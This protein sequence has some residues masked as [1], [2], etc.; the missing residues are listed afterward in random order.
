MHTV[1][2]LLDDVDYIAQVQR[3][4]LTTEKFGIEPTHGLYGSTE[5][6][7]QIASKALPTHTLRGVISSV[8]MGSMNDWPEFELTASDGSKTH[9]TR[10]ANSPELAK[11]Y[12]ANRAVE[13]DYVVQRFRQKAFTPN[14]ETKVVLEVRIGDVV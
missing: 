9:W 12:E 5:W 4:T 1:Y 6:W 2:R 7:S 11:L 3:A 8:Y 13:L 14:A 10:H